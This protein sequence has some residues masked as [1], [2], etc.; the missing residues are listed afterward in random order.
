MCFGWISLH[1]GTRCIMSSRTL[2][3]Q[4][5]IT[6]NMKI[7]LAATVSVPHTVSHY[8]LLSFVRA[9]S[10]RKMQ[11]PPARC[12]AVAHGSPFPFPQCGW[13]LF[14]GLSDSISMTIEKSWPAQGWYL[15]MA[16]QLL[17][18]LKKMPCGI[19]LVLG[20]GKKNV[21]SHVIIFV[22]K[23]GF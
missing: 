6:R 19:N 16:I 18:S 1:L 12:P 21:H 11:A 8:R 10:G 20:F 4:W 9:S 5:I 3:S 22:I 23:N 13:Y 2:K 7:D 17:G 15:F 14:T